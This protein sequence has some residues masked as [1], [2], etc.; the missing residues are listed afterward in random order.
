MQTTTYTTILHGARVKLGLS[1]NE[2]VCADV[3]DKL[4]NPICTMSREK[5]SAIIGVEKRSLTNIVNRLTEKG[6]ILNNEKGLLTTQLWKDSVNI[7][8][9]K[10]SSEGGKKFLQKRKKVPLKEEKSSS[11]YN[12]NDNNKDNNNDIY[13]DPLPA[14][15]G[16]SSLQRVIGVYSLIWKDLYG[17]EPTLNWPQ[18]G[19][20]FKPLLEQFNEW[21]LAALIDVH[22]NWHGASGDDNFI[23]KRLADAC[24]PLAWIPAN[25]NQYRAY[26][27]N[28]LNIN[29]DSLESVKRHV[30][31]IIK[32]LI[33]T[34]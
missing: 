26:I 10:T 7:D 25:V 31:E 13:T 32:P 16:K 11:Y 14:E 4:A 27:T 21:Q 22:F 15:L 28:T 34:K 17:F 2:Y 23:H 5:L 20:Q 18:L 30:V 33:K 24:F 29:F 19:K 6:I 9:E 12:Y 8:E 3:V 1:N